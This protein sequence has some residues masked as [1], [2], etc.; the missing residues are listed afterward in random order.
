MFVRKMNMRKLQIFTAATVLVGILS[1][2]CLLG[3]F[4]VLHDIYKDYASPG[5]L[6]EQA[7][8]SPETL[9][10]WTACPTE[11]SML[12]IGFW[13]ML[14]FHVMALATLALLARNKGLAKGRFQG[15]A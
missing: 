9:P 6:Y 2:L 10:D 3:Y 4:L 12:R 1:L 8:I 11:W 7:S 14:A 15:D 5:V 13:P